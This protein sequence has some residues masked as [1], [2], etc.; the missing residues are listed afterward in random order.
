MTLLAFAPFKPPDNHSKCLCS[1][2]RADIGLGQI[3]IHGRTERAL[4]TIGSDFEGSIS[5]VKQYPDGWSGKQ[6]VEYLRM[7]Q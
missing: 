3:C 5:L 7:A 2:L 1:A 4:I 6:G